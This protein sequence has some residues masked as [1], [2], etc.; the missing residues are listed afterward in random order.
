MS[1]FKSCPHCGAN[2]DPGEQCDCL[3]DLKDQE[4]DEHDAWNER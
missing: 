3:N 2:L 4:E 1:V